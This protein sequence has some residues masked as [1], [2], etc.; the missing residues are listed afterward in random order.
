MW[1]TLLEK[2]I[3][4]GAC[5]TLCITNSQIKNFILQAGQKTNKNESIIMYKPILSVIIEQTKQH[6]GLIRFIQKIP[7]NTTGNLLQ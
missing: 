2:L 4:L 5:L 1:V 7:I 3:V 6:L